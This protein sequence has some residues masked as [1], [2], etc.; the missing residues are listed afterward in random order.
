V[1][2][3]QR[4]RIE[5]V[6]PHQLGRDVFFTTRLFWDCACERYYIHPCTEQI[7]PVCKA[8]RED[9]PDARV[10][11]VFRYSADLDRRLVEALTALCEVVCPDLIIGDLP[12]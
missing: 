3:D 5:L 9:A 2:P 12:F 11:E 4:P 10:E 8:D 1:C 7:C 6:E